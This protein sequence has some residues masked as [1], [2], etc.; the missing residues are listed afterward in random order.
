MSGLD[1]AFF[2]WLNATAASPAWVVP[3]ARF[4]TVQLPEWMIVGLAAAFLVGDAR[5]QRHVSRVVLA[6]LAGWLLA[7]LGQHLFPM[8]RPF[9]LG[10]GTAW[11]THADSAGF[12]STHASVAFAFAFAVAACTRRW[13][14]AAAAFVVASLIG[15][16]RI[17]LGLHFPV[18][19]LAGAAVGGASAWLSGL[20]PLYRLKSFAGKRDLHALPVSRAK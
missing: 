2:L 13:L 17:S 14:P 7:R 16:S 8:P 15:W 20:V 11:K 9:S 3:F 18:D 10:L 6:L 4:V 5:V 19:V 12:P 1:V